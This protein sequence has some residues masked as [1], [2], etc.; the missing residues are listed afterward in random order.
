MQGIVLSLTKWS[1]DLSGLV[2]FNCDFL[3]GSFESIIIKNRVIVAPTGN[4]I[5]VVMRNPSSH[6]D[7]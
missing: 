5:E 2:G 3:F 6:V 4:Y 7:V 1:L